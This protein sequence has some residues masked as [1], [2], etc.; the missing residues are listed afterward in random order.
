[1]SESC[2]VI[3]GKGV[4]DIMGWSKEDG[5][6]VYSLDGVPIAGYD[7]HGVPVPGIEGAAD[8]I[9]YRDLRQPF[10][11]A[12][13]ASVTLATTQK[14]LWAVGASSPTILPANYWTVGKTVQITANLKWTAV[15]NTNGITPGMQYGAADAAACNVAATAVTPVSSTS[16][17]DVFALGYATC[18]SIGT[19]GTLSMWGFFSLP[20]GLTVNSP[21]TFPSAGVTV[22]STIDTT[23]G[24]NAVSFQAAR[25]T[26]AGDTVVVTNLLMEALN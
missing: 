7:R 14:V 2:M 24:T 21:A 17:F 6:P 8:G 11:V 3:R 26:A 20:I 22:V 23:V 18:R 1:M 25:A 9:F 4:P 10:I 12:D 16:T 15:A 5:S 19:A 13:I